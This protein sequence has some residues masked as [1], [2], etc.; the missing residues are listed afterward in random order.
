MNKLMGKR[1]LVT[2]ASRG[3]G[4]GIA[5]A[6]ADQG[7]DVAITYERSVEQA[8]EVV[9]AIEAKGRR[10]L[11]IRADS[12]DAAAVRRSVDEAVGALGGLDILVNNA[13]VARYGAIEDVSLADIDALLNINVR[14]AVLATQA[15]IPHLGE[16]GRIVSIGSC[17]GE[18]VPLGGST[19]YSMTK[20]ALL[21]FT[22]GLARD[23]GPRQI[24][25][26][27]VQ[28]GPIDTDM[29]PADGEHAEM[30]RGLTAL[31]R[32]GTPADI[33]AVVTFLAS[34]AANFV[35]GSVVTVDGGFNA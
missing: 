22:R 2:G 14:A 30:L 27:L 3:I 33:A 21:A 19:L 15:A 26:N 16:G 12:A 25:A 4:A 34:P 8:N 6:L 5:L 24:T 35:T 18:R 9:R 29:N 23:V 17:L 7:A 11:A 32:Y 28:P 10:A 13:G 1:A 20:S 31:G